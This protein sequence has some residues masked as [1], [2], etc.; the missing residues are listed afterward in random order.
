[1]TNVEVDD[2]GPLEP[3]AGRKAGAPEE[4]YVERLRESGDDEILEVNP[5]CAYFNFSN[6][7]LNGLGVSIGDDVVGYYKRAD[8][9]WRRE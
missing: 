7:V 1:M 8:R 6:R 9:L 3:R 2:G 5:V 4:R